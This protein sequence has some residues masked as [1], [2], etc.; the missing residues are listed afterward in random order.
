M[1]QTNSRPNSSKIVIP[2]R[3]ESN[4]YILVWIYLKLFPCIEY[5]FPLFL[6]KT[7]L[8][9]PLRGS[10]FGTHWHGCLN[11]TKT[12]VWSDLLQ[13]YEQSKEVCFFNFLE[14]TKTKTFL[15]IYKSVLPDMTEHKRTV[16]A[17]NKFY[18]LF[19]KAGILLPVIRAYRVCFI[20]WTF[21]Q[22]AIFIYLF[23]I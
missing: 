5:L 19:S 9:L 10:A 6:N 22:L 7:S 11:I 18:L 13:S 14:K 8:T 20:T 3:D 17:A 16:R 1:L 2:Q 23:L 15:T 12:F 4:L 21:L